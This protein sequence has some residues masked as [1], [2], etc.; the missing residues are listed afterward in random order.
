[1]N[2]RQ[3]TN[4]AR[5]IETL[6]KNGLEIYEVDTLLRCERAL[7]RWAEREAGDGSD[8][9]I[10][11]DEATGKPFNVYH[12]NAERVVTIPPRRYAIPDRETAAY[13][14]ALKIATAH[15]LTAFHQ[16]DCRGCGLYLL[17][18]GDVRDGERADQVYSRGVAICL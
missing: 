12:G 1:M 3:A 17:R 2:K 5:L 13:N 18:P 8:W 4:Y 16:G 9:V 7:Q 10:E 14:R 11:R 15:G 6:K